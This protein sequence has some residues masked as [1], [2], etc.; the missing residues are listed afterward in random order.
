MYALKEKKKLR[1][2]FSIL[3]SNH[4]LLYVSF[5]GLNILEKNYF[6]PRNKKYIRHTKNFKY[7]IEYPI[8]QKPTLSI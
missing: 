5:F 6:V 7:L 1:M 4:N 2:R 3:Y 8:L